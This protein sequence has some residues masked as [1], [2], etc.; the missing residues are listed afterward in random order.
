[1]VSL[2][3]VDLLSLGCKL[4]Q[5]I[6]TLGSPEPG[7][8]VEEERKKIM[9]AQY[10]CFEKMNRDLPYNKSGIRP[11]LAVHTATTSVSPASFPSSTCRHVWCLTVAYFG[12]GLGLYCNRTWDGWMCWDDTPAGTFYTQNCPDYFPDFDPTGSCVGFIFYP[13]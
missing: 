3:V 13:I 9:D 1:M 8:T 5:R 4:Q 11:M 2:H 10:K 7:T 6:S 12:G